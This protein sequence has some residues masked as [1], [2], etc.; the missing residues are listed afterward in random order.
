MADLVD[1][2]IQQKL[3]ET[4]NNPY[5]RFSQTAAK[6]I[7]PAAFSGDDDWK[8]AA[9]TGAITGLTNSWGKEKAQEDALALA[10]QSSQAKAA[11]MTGQDYD[12]AKFGQL[13]EDMYGA[14][15]ANAQAEKQ[16]AAIENQRKLAQLQ[17]EKVLGNQIDKQFDTGIYYNPLASDPAQRMAVDRGF[18]DAMNNFKQ[19]GSYATQAG[20]LGAQRDIGP[21]VDYA[22]KM[23]GYQADVAGKPMVMKAEAEAQQQIDASNPTKLRERNVEAVE[24][25]MNLRKDL[26]S[27]EPFKQFQDIDKNF[28]S[29]IG[30]A[31]DNSGVA[32]EALVRYTIQAIEPGMAVRE[33]EA[34]AIANSQALSSDV[35]GIMLKALNGEARLQP[36]T[37]YKILQHIARHQ[38]AAAQQLET[39][40]ADQEAVARQGYGLNPAEYGV[41]F[42]PYRTT[43]REVPS[44]DQIRERFNSTG[45]S[46]R[47]RYEQLK[48]K[49]G[50]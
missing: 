30:A 21:S 4:Y 13:G 49:Y 5:L 11:A 14:M 36:E 19:R 48:A 46:E 27:S 8:Y 24:T 35:K 47:Q 38:Q 3:T 44:L 23:A 42:N 7:D 39:L 50:R 2:L 41:Q 20:S 34:A 16:Q 22:R 43:A 12:P 32:D 1:A 45:A 33:G 10:L 40:V 25:L 18:Q 26:R 6:T 9:L 28:Q 17:Q 31:L 37:R 15:L 29:A